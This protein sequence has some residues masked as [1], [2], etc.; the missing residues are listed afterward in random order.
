MSALVTGLLSAVK[1]VAIRILVA[2]FSEKMLMKTALMAAEA[3]VAK[4]DTN[5]DDLWLKDLKETL[6]GK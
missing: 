5:K 4:T 3:I 2:T 1:S 6:E